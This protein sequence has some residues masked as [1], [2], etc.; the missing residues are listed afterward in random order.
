MK[1]NSSGNIFLPKKKH[2][3][4]LRVDAIVKN[5]IFDGK[6]LPPLLRAAVDIEPG[7]KSLH[8]W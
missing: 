1:V 4:I 5:T 2:S 8:D 7:C 3:R 6:I